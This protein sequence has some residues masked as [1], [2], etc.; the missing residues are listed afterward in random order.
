LILTGLLNQGGITANSCD[1]NFR[2]LK[3]IYEKTNQRL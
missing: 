2:N 3:R 1:S